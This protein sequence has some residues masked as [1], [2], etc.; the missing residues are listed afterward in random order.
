MLRLRE[1]ICLGDLMKGKI[2]TYL[3]YAMIIDA[4][5]S[6]ITCRRAQYS[7]DAPT[8]ILHLRMTVDVPPP[9]PAEAIMSR[10]DLTKTAIVYS[11]GLATIAVVALN[12][13]LK[14]A[15]L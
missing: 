5:L 13:A 11:L 7:T 8:C 1:T 2:G 15:A 9:I 12:G 4:W 10:T 14:F 3:L 6:S